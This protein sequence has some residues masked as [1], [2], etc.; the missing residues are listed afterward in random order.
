MCQWKAALSVVFN[1]NKELLVKNVEVFKCSAQWIFVFWFEV[2]SCIFLT[3]FGGTCSWL[4]SRLRSSAFMFSIC[5]SSSVFVRLASSITLYREPISSSTAF[6]NGCSFSYL[7][8]EGGRYSSSSSSSSQLHTGQTLSCRLLCTNV[9]LSGA[10][11]L[12]KPSLTEVE[13]TFCLRAE[14]CSFDPF[15]P[16]LKCFSYPD[17]I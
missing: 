17:C 2:K 13:L 11:K 12:F 9:W 10:K 5:S 1:A 4:C 6:L 7:R 8:D 15:T 14:F 16:A 3:E